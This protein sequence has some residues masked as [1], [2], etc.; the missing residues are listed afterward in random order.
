MKKYTTNKPAY[1]ANNEEQDSIMKKYTTNK[2][3]YEAIM[4]SKIL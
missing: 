1:Q 3:D 2:P 4:K